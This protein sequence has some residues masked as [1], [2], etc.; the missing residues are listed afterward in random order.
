MKSSSLRML[1]EL[2]KDA[3]P[4]EP[5]EQQPDMTGWT[6]REIVDWQIAHMDIVAAHGKARLS[7]EPPAEPTTREQFAAWDARDAAILAERAAKAAAEHAAHEPGETAQKAALDAREAADKA[8]RAAEEAERLAEE[9]KLRPPPVENPDA[10]GPAAEPAE[11]KAKPKRRRTRKPKPEPE[12]KPKEWWEER[13]RW[14]KRSSWEDED[15]RRG[16]P[17]Y[18]C[19]HEYDP[20]AAFYDEWEEE[21]DLPE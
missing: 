4:Q 8:A 21:D 7:P 11:A 15:A 10:P 19:I 18:E 3:Q 16:R 5:T 9:A 1:E 6:R 12:P 14:R 2:R 20:I 17:L 13:A